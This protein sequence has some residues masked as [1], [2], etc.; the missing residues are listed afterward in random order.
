MDRDSRIGL[1]SA[2]SRGTRLLFVPPVVGSQ[3]HCR[4][5]G[6][7]FGGCQRVYRASDAAGS[8]EWRPSP[9][10]QPAKGCRIGLARQAWPRESRVSAGIV[11]LLHNVTG[12]LTGQS[13]RRSAR[14]SR[15][16]RRGTQPQGCLLHNVTGRNQGSRGGLGKG[17][18]N[19][20]DP[21]PF[22]RESLTYPAFA[23]WVI[24]RS[25]RQIRTTRRRAVAF[26][27][28][29]PREGET[30]ANWQRLFWRW[31]FLHG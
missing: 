27:Y 13:R 29:S 26:R 10:V 3:L 11:C 22:A 5:Q 7:H 9:G 16:C 23:Q 6:T 28:P 31:S 21:A 12:R 17:P 19:R 4:S 8:Q 18:R 14:T 20:T 1:L 30:A 25:T 15:G 2:D 24:G